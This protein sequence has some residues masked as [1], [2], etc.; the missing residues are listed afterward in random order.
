MLQFLIDLRFVSQRVADDLTQ[1]LLVALAEAVDDRAEGIRLQPE[2][3]SDRL[4]LPFAGVERQEGASSF[5]LIH[6]A[7]RL[8]QIAGGDTLSEMDEDDEKCNEND[9]K[10]GW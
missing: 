4:V 10:N 3:L 1:R 7:P 6:L 8:V 5:E 9:Q 2:T